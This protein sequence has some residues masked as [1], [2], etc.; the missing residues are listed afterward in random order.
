MRFVL[1]D[2]Q[3]N[4]HDLL[5]KS[6]ATGIKI[7]TLRLSAIEVYKCANDLN[8]EYLNEI[9]TIK[10][11]PYDFRDNSILERPKSNT[12]LVRS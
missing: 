3:S 9:L 1:N 11:C 6:E 12:N 8:P 7:T 10:N 5:N 4:Y 2:Y